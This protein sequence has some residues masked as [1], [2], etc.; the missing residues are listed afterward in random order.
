MNFANNLK[1]LR[2][3]NNITQEQLADFLQVSRPTIAGY[4]T[5]SR[6]PDFER[7]TKI[8]QFFHVSI[9][10]LLNGSEYTLCAQVEQPLPEHIVDSEVLKLYHSLSSESKQDAWKYLKLLKLRDEQR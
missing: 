1:F 5:K 8:S 2:E 4:E 10:Y 6:Q 9:D 3:S 7:L